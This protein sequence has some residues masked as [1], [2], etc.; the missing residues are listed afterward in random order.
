MKHFFLQPSLVDPAYVCGGWQIFNRAAELAGRLRDVEV[1]TYRHREAGTRYLDDVPAEEL[2]AGLVWT[3]WSAHVTELSRRLAGHPRVVLYA[4]NT[5]YG[6]DHGQVTPPAWPL[7]CLSRFLAAAWSEADP[8]RL[9]H[10]L[11]PVLHADARNPRREREVDVLAHVRKLPPYV[12]RELLPAL[13]ES[14]LRVEEVGDWRPQEEMLALFQEARVYLYW[15]H[16]QIGGLWIH[17]GF[18]MQPLEAIACGALPVSN[19]YGGMSDYLEPPT[20][21]RKIGVWDLAY[22]VEQVTRAAREHD[23]GNVDEERLRRRYSADTF[24]ARFPEIERDLLA[25]FSGRRGQRPQAFSLMP[26]R[27]PLSRRLRAGAYRFVR[28]RYKRLRGILPR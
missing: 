16:R 23:G 27:E 3:Y 10:Y 20:N 17:E 24:L 2:H 4:M 15:V 1:L 5:D 6:R 25:Y 28:R 21:C 18:G 19:L 22:D 9:V 14:G 12:R 26:P 8:W 13:V 11:G 7:V